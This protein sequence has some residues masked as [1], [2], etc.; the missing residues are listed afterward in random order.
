M[1][2]TGTRGTSPLPSF[3]PNRPGKK[4]RAVVIGLVA[5]FVLLAGYDLISS[6]ALTSK[7]ASSR[8]AGPSGSP[9]AAGKPTATAR[10]PTRPASPSPVASAPTPAP[11]ELTVVSAAAFGPDGTSDGDN[12]DVASRVLP[13][14][15]S[16]GWASA[17]YTTPEFGGLQSGTGLL[18]DMGQ[19]VSIQR[20]RLELGDSPGADV[21]LLV[22]N[23]PDMDSLSTVASRSDAG[24]TVALT[25]S[26]PVSARYVLVWFTS[27]PPDSTG[28]YQVTVYN[29]TVQGQP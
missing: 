18:L 5:V 15:G 26:S 8:A 28:T 23:T 16:A 10:P 6:G 21:H 29:V 24:G 7:A 4:W 25:L 11:Q 20:V 27:L 19:T 17:W 13:G 2:V 3:T 22:G 9:R 1:G 12:P 14:G